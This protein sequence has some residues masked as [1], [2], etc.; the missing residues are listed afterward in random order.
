MSSGTN[1]R[2]RH[3]ARP[4]TA[5]QVLV[6]MLVA[7]LGGALFNAQAILRT[8]EQQELGRRRS[9]AVA[10]AE[11]LASVSGFLRIDE[12]RE[13]I[14]DA[15]GRGTLR[16]DTTITTPSTTTTTSSTTTPPPAPTTT[17]SPGTQAPTTT[18][19][20]GSQAPTTTSTT[21]T[22]TTTTTTVPALREVT[23]EQPLDLWIVGDSFVELFG[24]ALVNRGLD[25]GL[26]N[27]DPDFRYSSG[28]SRPDFFDWPAY[29]AAE[30]AEGE[31]DAAV[32]IFGGNDGVD[33]EL[34]GERFNLGTDPWVDLY[35]VRVAE[36]MDVLLTGVERV[37]WIGLPV[38]RSDSFTAKAHTMNSVYQS[39]ADKR[40]QIT[41]IS[42]FE[43]FEGD[44]GGYSA[45]VD[46][47]QVRWRDGAHFTW[48]GAY[49]LA[50]F[51][52]P[53]ILEDWNVR[54]ATEAARGSPASAPI[55][56][57]AAQILGS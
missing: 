36:A 24:P 26:V 42:S 57:V 10:L 35:A 27:A 41:Y 20:S 39:E 37:Y 22:T 1:H 38:M 34:G 52:L 40:P 2:H 18:A 19:G 29:I 46:G 30:L 48:N 15:L 55:K 21:S 17:A 25:T 47:E 5:R 45:Y 49:R 4:L 54:Q 23:A 31:R 32:I 8:A 11:P 7:L 51:V 12:P 9:V 16:R 28:L 33:V 56:E 43:L 13:A 14:D 50:D 53:M 44:D 3:E 6:V